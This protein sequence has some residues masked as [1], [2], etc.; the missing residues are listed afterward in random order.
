MSHMIFSIEKYIDMISRFYTKK[1]FSTAKK[2]SE[3]IFFFRKNKL[4][5]IFSINQTMILSSNA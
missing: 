3:I 4:K 2:L 1:N 5:D